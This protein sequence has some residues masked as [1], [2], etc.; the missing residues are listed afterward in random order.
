MCDM[1]NRYVEN[2]YIFLLRQIR[3]K[4]AKI[5]FAVEVHINFY[6][7]FSIIAFYANT[8]LRHHHQFLLSVSCIVFFHWNTIQIFLLE[9]NHFHLSWKKYFCYFPTSYVR[10]SFD[11]FNHYTVFWLMIFFSCCTTMQVILFMI[12]SVLCRLHTCLA[13]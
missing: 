12:L 9:C 8:S 5:V 7:I 1:E 10:C 3:Q 6:H 2:F 4:Q 11:I 13:V